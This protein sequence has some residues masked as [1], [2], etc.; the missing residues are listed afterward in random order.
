[1]GSGGGIVEVKGSF[2]SKFKCKGDREV[3]FLSYFA[4]DELT[5]LYEKI[6]SQSEY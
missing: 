2:L 4:L 1:M 6:V 3:V 5:C